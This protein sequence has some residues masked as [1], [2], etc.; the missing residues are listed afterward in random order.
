MNKTK[1][2]SRLINLL[3]INNLNSQGKVKILIKILVKMNLNPIFIK[4]KN[5]INKI[6]N[7]LIRKTIKINSFLLNL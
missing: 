5:K 1:V 2:W 3:I 6:D 4:V 7:Y